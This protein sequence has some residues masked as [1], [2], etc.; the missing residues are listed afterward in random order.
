[1]NKL[2]LARKIAEEFELP[3]SKSGSIVTYALDIMSQTLVS[4]DPITLIGFGSFSVRNRKERN[5]RNPQTGKSIKIPASKVIKFTA[6]KS[7]KSAI[8]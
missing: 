5:G 6:G 1:M 4:G 8:N 7:L 3:L 2:D